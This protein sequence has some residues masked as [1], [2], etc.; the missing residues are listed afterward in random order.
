MITSGT[1]FGT[2]CGTE[3]ELSIDP[4]T[5][6]GMWTAGATHRRAPSDAPAVTAPGLMALSTIGLDGYP[7][8]RH[9]LLS[10][11]DATAVYFHTDSRSEKVR[12]IAEMPRAACALVWP[13]AGR[14]LVMHGD[15]QVATPE[16]MRRAYRARSRYLQILAWCNDID[17]ARASTAERRR[18][19]ADFAAQNE[20]LDPPSTWIGYALIPHEIVFWRGDP[21]GP[22]RRIRFRRVEGGHW[23]SEVLS[24]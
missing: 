3:D 7:R 12:Q 16:E 14:Q 21:E 1:E 17:A 18:A 15:L 13:Q 6:V 8:V 5:L 23:H 10:E 4:M 11:C 2:D 24:G 20:H 22:S 19:W 9:V